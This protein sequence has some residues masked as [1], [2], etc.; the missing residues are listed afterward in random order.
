MRTQ[1]RRRIT[2]ASILIMFLAGL[3]GF[4]ITKKLSQSSQLQAKAQVGQEFNNTSP[5]ELAILSRLRSIV[6]EL[7]KE[8]DPS[9]ASAQ[10]STVVKVIGGI[11]QRITDQIFNT[12]RRPSV[13][14]TTMARLEPSTILSAPGNPLPSN[15]SGS[16]TT[17]SPST[18]SS[19]ALSPFTESGSARVTSGSAKLFIEN[20][21]VNSYIDSSQQVFISVETQA[22]NSG[23]TTSANTPLKI[24]MT[25]SAGESILLGEQL[26]PSLAPNTSSSKKVSFQCPKSGS[27]EVCV[28]IPAQLGI[29]SHSSNETRVCKIVSVPEVIKSTSPSSSGGVSIGGSSPGALTNDS[30]CLCNR[31]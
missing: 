18:S 7:K 16:V 21:S 28:T 12:T 20:F 10:V 1:K 23:T 2:F 26:I 30:T 31:Q 22:R 14:P 4:F 13:I 17:G 29:S 27:A 8:A 6:N 5:D 11:P 19:V 3:G 24:F 9:Y 25:D 15:P